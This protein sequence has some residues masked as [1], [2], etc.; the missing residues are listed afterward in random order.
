MISIEDLNFTYASSSEPALH[1]VS[2]EIG[3]GEF[4]LVIGKSGSGKSTLCRAMNGLIPHFYGGTI[5]GRV[6][7]DGLDTRDNPPASLANR[8]GMV[9]QDPENQLVM[10]N[11]ENEL[12]FG[13]ENLA[14]PRA[15]MVDRI[16]QYSSYFDLDN[17]LERFIPEL[18]GGEKQKV[19]L[20]S[21]LAM[22]PRYLILDEPTS[23]LDTENTILF[24]DYLKRLNSEF[25]VSIILVE[26]RLERCLKYADRILHVEGGEVVDDVGGD[27][28]IQ[29]MRDS[30]LFRSLRTANS[31]TSP[32]SNSVI[33]ANSVNFSYDSTSVLNDLDLEVGEGEV[34]AITGSNGSGKSTLLK[35]IMG[36]LKPDGGQITALGKDVA[37]TTPAS[38]AREIGYLGQNPNDY[39]FEENLRKELQFTLKHL[40]IDK[41]EWEER[42]RWVLEVVDLM[43][44]ED[45]FSRDFSCGERERAAIASILVGRPDILILDEPTRGLDYWNK[46]KLGS[47]LTSLR[48]KGISTL[49]VTH[50]HK[51]IINFATRILRLK[52]GQIRDVS[53]DDFLEAYHKDLVMEEGR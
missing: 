45:D 22:R 16:S 36:L 11:V 30:G 38:L 7:V 27:D 3:G 41:D 50:D 20:A 53:I 5:S 23:Q 32:N 35:L 25:G 24:L 26:H 33:R 39:L 48:E 9:F 31:F 34:L 37:E 13:M 12:A 8:V 42:I 17:F 21:V 4:I 19:A 15:V 10:T 43:G 14:M 52:D 6:F 29:F 40:G 2:L 46:E 49:L 47:V 44:H 1:N 18:S 51:F 28:E